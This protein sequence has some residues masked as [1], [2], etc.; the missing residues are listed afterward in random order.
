MTDSNI[1][2]LLGLARTAQLAGNSEEALNYF[3]RVLEA[4]PNLSEAW[5]GK[6]KAAGWLSSLVHIRVGEAIVAFGHAIAT[7][8]EAD[9]PDIT[10][11]AVEEVNRIVVALYGMAR[12][13]LEDF[14]ALPASWEQYL[15]QVAQL[16]NGLDEVKNWIQNDRSTLENVV[17]LCKDNIEGVGYNDPFDY[18]AYKTWN[19]SPEYEALLKARLDGAVSTLREIDPA[20]AA[21]TIEKKTADCFVVTATMGDEGH[22]TVK[23]MRRFRDERLVQKRWGRGLIAQYYRLG[24]RAARV[25][26]PSLLLRSLSFVLLVAPVAFVVKQLTRN[27]RDNAKSH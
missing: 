17:Y 20:Y 9:K 4:D 24:P 7:A 14:V 2:N 23:L 3:N 11:Q 19:L 6:G 15:N 25:I 1:S 16:L 21:P 12:R 5:M 10:F 8:P 26:A 27:A 13:H 22:P 18:N